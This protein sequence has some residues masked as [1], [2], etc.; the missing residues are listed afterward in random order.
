VRAGNLPSVSFLKAASFEDG[1][2]GY[3]NP[4]DEQHFLA[5]TLD[6]LEKSPE[7]GSTAVVITY[8]DSDGWYDHKAAGIL[9]HSDV[10]GSDAA[11]MCNN[12]P[13]AAGVFKDR[14]GPGPRLPLLVVS[15][16]TDPNT[17]VNNTQLEQASIIQFIEHNWLG[18]ARLGNQSFDAR[19]G[20]LRSM[21]DFNANAPKLY[22]DPST[23]EPVD[24]PPDVVSSPNGPDPIATPTPV[25]TVSPTPTPTPTVTPPFRIKPKLSVT[26]KRSGRKLTLK[27][28]VTNLKAA[29]GRITLTVKLRRK[30]KTLAS[31]ARHTVRSG[32]VTLVLKAKQPL[33]K[34]RY[35]LGVRIVQGRATG[36]LTRTVTLR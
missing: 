12:G 23:G 2:A 9:Q 30:G 15:P 32:R 11:P 31:S 6:E 5:R 20:D 33:K 4:L 18:D 34:G 21:F 17:V 24:T 1:H 36:N 16:Y 27:L 22:L 13:L 35:T 8:D 14:C 29:N 10:V 19:A 7:W 25:P 28:K 26:A 3:S